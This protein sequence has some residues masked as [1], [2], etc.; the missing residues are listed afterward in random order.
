METALIILA[1]VLVVTGVIGNIVPM[2]PGTPLSF[3]AL[4]ILQHT[5]DGEAF[6]TTALIVFGALTLFS[7]AF[8]FV[9]PMVTAKRFGASAYGIWGSFLGM[10]TGLI[11]FPP[12]GALL[13]LMAGAVAGELLAGK[14]SEEALK[15]GAAT[16][17]GNA[18]SVI[19]RLGLS[20]T[21]G[22]MFVS[23]LV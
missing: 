22:V 9:L 3:A 12:L 4:L 20:L 2:L 13:G 7:L 10:I 15:A 17:A 19:L 8:D 6:S 5:S 1:M 16:V 23:A 11:L 14:R 21:M 18:A